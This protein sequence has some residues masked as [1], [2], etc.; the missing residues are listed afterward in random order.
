[1]IVLPQTLTIPNYEL[2]I[3]L[4]N[5]LENA[6]EACI[7]Q[8]EGKYIELRLKPLGEQLALM[9]KNSFNGTLMQNNSRPESTKT[10]GGFGLKSVEAVVE[11]YYGELTTQWDGETFT[12]GVTVQL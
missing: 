7:H 3:I 5:L 9:V 12:A 11:H 6:V 8:V 1:M 10:D 4:G 2:C